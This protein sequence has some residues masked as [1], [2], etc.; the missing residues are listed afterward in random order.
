MQDDF[1]RIA[2]EMYD[3]YEAYDLPSK[4]LRL[5]RPV[6]WL[7]FLLPYAVGF[8]F[9]VT[10]QTN[11]YHAVFGLVSFAF[12]MSFSFTINALFDRDVDRLHDGR[13]K[14]LNLSMQPLVTGE[15]SVKEAKILCALF[16][17]LSMVFAAFINTKFFF[18]MLGANI[19]GY[20]YSAPPRF[21]AKPV[22]DVICNALAAVLVFYAGLSIGGADM[23]FAV[24]IAAFFLAATFYIP[25]AVSDYEFDK[26][27]GLKNTPVYFGPRRALMSL[28]PLAAITILLWGYVFLVAQR[29]E[30]KIISPLIILYTLAYTV[31]I[32]SRWDGKKLNVTPHIILTPFGIISA[33]FI[34]YGFA[35]ILKGLIN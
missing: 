16:F 4:Y 35:V 33:L 5:L 17:I 19:I 30:V 7:C 3:A 9:G 2:R 14:D 10:P 28:Y 22:A 34:A 24:Y 15:I 31:V 1:P 29:L 12:W 23:P 20:V 27:A 18:A 13:V 11:Y 32:N 25:T 26:A 6:A 8:G 21:K